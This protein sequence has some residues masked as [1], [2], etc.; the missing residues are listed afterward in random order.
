MTVSI[1]LIPV[2]QG[3]A[4]D[5][6]LRWMH[7]RIWKSRLDIN[8]SGMWIMERGIH[9]TP[10]P[11]T[12]LWGLSSLPLSPSI[13]IRYKLPLHLPR[14]LGAINVPRSAL[15][16]FKHK[17]LALVQIKRDDS[18]PILQWRIGLQLF[19]LLSPPGRHNALADVPDALLQ[20]KP[21]IILPDFCRERTRKISH[22]CYVYDN[23][24]NFVHCLI[25]RGDSWYCCRKM[26][27]HLH[28]ISR[29]FSIAEKQSTY[30]CRAENPLSFNYFQRFNER[31]HQSQRAL[32]FS[33]YFMIMSAIYSRA[34]IIIVFQL[35]IA[36][37]RSYHNYG[38][39]VSS[40]RHCR[41]I[42]R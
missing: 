2:P 29:Y 33:F 39:V 17:F 12:L 15:H 35:K 16:S 3:I 23:G 38:A 1:P 7:D 31:H 27:L 11:R 18:I 5:L 14:Y 25:R 26:L 19:M 13:F 36:S 10:H 34:G 37:K 32:P 22:N 6:H 8:L 30:N 42:N 20:I 4:L 21:E 40:G 41:K 28:I 9:Y 24:L